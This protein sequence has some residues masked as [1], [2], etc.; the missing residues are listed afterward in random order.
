M[1]KYKLDK[2]PL[3]DT[4]ASSGDDTTAPAVAAKYIA[5]KYPT[6]WLLVRR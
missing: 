6:G 5:R 1:A 2:M 4:E 3:W